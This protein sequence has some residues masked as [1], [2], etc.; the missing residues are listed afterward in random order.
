VTDLGTVDTTLTLLGQHEELVLSA[1]VESQVVKVFDDVRA[2]SLQS[3][4]RLDLAIGLDTQLEAGDQ[5]VR[6]L[7][8]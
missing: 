7:Q 6:N 2:C 5:R 8:I 3:L 4:S 1:E